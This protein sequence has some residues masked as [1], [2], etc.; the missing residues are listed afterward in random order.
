MPINVYAWPPVGALSSEWTRVQPKAVTR[1]MLT[2]RQQMQ[3]SQRERRMATVEISALSAG[4]SGAGYC[5]ML[6]RYLAGGVH[7]VRLR[8]PSINWHLDQIQRA[9]LLNST[10]LRWTMPP[11]S[12][13]WISGNAD[14]HWFDGVVVR[15][16]PSAPDPGGAW[17]ILSLT[18]LPPNRLI[19]RAGDYLRAYVVDNEA[20]SQVAQ[21]VTDARSRE[22]GT[23]SVRIF[24]AITLPDARINLAGQ[25]EA[26]FQVEGDLP[27]SVQPL[28]SNWSYTWNLR[29]VFADE[30]G[31]F[32][33]IN[34][35]T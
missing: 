24:S 19:V 32:V 18:G 25:D 16:G 14:L 3:A 4:R 5:E 6:K 23:A 12:I 10:P 34:P 31:G 35:W 15:G 33:E 17:H 21:V 27:R 1:S 9:A 29:E 8:S 2:G 13:G 20:V 7:A 11:E 22:D 28:G 26:V 30:V